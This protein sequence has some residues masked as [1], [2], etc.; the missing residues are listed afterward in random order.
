MGFQSRW[1][2]RRCQEQAVA[3]AGFATT[4]ENNESTSSD[5]L[6]VRP[7]IHGRHTCDNCL[8]TPIIGKRYHAANRPNYDICEACYD[9]GSVAGVRFELTEDGKPDEVMSSFC[10]LKYVSQIVA[11]FPSRSSIFSTGSS[12][13]RSLASSQPSHQCE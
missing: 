5:A 1:H 3:E 9:S 12:L 6:P 2:D 13:P 8:A 4:T 10:F 11:L 7:F